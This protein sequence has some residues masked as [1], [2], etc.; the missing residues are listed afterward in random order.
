MGQ[1]AFVKDTEASA[2][3]VDKLGKAGDRAG[4]GAKGLDKFAKSAG[5][6]QSSGRALSRNVTLPLL[7]VGA[8]A[9]KTAGIEL[10]GS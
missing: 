10:A 9:V 7:A 1:R 6:M 3:S 4:R 2:R 5:R 8:A